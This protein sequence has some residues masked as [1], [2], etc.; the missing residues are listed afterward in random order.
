MITIQGKGVSAGVGVGPL[1]FY[2]RATAEIK[3]YTVEDTD[4]EWH[5]F[6]GAQT[7]AVEQL[8]DLAEQARR[9]AGDE[10][11]ML[12]ETHQMMAED[13]DYEEAI[14]DRISQIKG[15]IEHTDSDFDKEKLQERM[16]KLSGGVAVI[17]V[18]AQTEVAM[19]EQKLRVEDALNATRAAVEE[20]IVAGGGTAYVNAIP[21]V[22]KLVAKLSGDEKTGA[23]IIAR[24]LQAHQHDDCR[25]VGVD[26]DMLGIAAHELAKLLVDDLHDHLGRS[27]GFQNVGADAA[28]GDGFG[29]I[30]DH[31][32]A[33]V[34]FQQRHANLPHS[35]LYVRLFQASLAAQF[36]EGRGNLFG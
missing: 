29:K 36:F 1:Y 5:R 35:L 32:I 18:G 21:A 9:D 23:Q 12:F 30:L 14:E 16:A 28:L 22:E 10:A 34:R 27:Q 4:A 33:D 24:A 15:E 17:K 11:A 6:K 25:A 26:V 3:R 20:G 7:G 2:R 19:K 13:L 31:L 8:G